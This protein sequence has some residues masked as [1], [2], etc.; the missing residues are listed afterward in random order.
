MVGIDEREQD[1][2]FLH[3]VDDLDRRRLYA[4]HD[5]RTGDERLGVGDEGD[6]AVGRIGQLGIVTGAGLHMQFSAEFDEPRGHRGHE[7]DAALVRPGLFQNGDVD[8]HHPSRMTLRA[9][10]F[11]ASA[12]VS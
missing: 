6:I 5:V 7:R 12:N 2:A 9:P 11:A 1:R 10:V 3:L 8:E 4:Q